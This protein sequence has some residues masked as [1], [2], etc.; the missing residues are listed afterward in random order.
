MRDVFNDFIPA[1]YR[2]WL[3]AA[4]VLIVLLLIWLIVRR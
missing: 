4:A 1:K 3:M 2:P